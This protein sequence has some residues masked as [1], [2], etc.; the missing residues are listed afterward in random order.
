MLSERLLGLA[1]FHA[2]QEH[3]QDGGLWPAS[4]M[5]VFNSGFVSQATAGW[6]VSLDC[7]EDRLRQSGC[8]CHMA[9]VSGEGH[10]NRL[11]HKVS[12]N[13][14]H[15]WPFLP[16]LHSTFS[17]VSLLVESVHSGRAGSLARYLH[18]SSPERQH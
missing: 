16:Y 5:S 14:E 2:R 3:K 13:L 9:P 7:G 8:V 1:R 11:H 6:S 17:Q 12:S 4:P 18:P 15:H 10:R